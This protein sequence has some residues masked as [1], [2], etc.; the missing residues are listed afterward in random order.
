VSAQRPSEEAAHAALL[1]YRERVLD[2]IR[3]EAARFRAMGDD[4]EYNSDAMEHTAD[5]EVCEALAAIIEA[6]P[7]V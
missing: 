6:I 1:A 3:K 5:A 7:L 4:A 2:A